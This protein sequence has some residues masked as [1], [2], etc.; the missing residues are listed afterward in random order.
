MLVPMVIESSSRGERAYDIYSR[1]LRERIVFLGD[2]IEDNV[3]N[4]V[5]AQLLFL[6][7]E[8]P[9]RDISLYIN[10]PGGVVTSGLAIYDTMQYVRAP[11]STI[12]IGMAASMAA[13]L[14]AA[15][16][17]GKRF[18]L[19][20]SRIMIHQGSGGFRGN[21][22]DVFI[23]VKEMESLVTL[24]NEILSKHTGQSLEKVIADTSRD[25]FMSP[26]EAKDYGIIDAVYSAVGSPLGSKS[27]GSTGKDDSPA[28]PES[29]GPEVA[30]E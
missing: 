17:P 20:H 3:A 26:T 14:L 18:A 5:I 8:D 11:V 19:P 10:S 7:A 21:T 28:Q 13:V 6:D 30:T 23:Q 15:G 27:G 12:C 29:A 9:E 22:P 4:L 24:N 2:G 1:L 16:A 25:Y